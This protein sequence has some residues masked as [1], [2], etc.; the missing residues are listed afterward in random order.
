MRNIPILFIFLFLA[1]G[2]CGQ[3]TQAPG[4]TQ[5]LPP[6]TQS[7]KIGPQGGPSLLPTVLPV[8]KQDQS[9]PPYNPT[10]KPDP[11]QP[12]RVSLEAKTGA[13]T[14]V[15]PLEQFEINDF[16]L[17]GIVSGP[18][19]K[20][21]MVQDLTGKGFLVQVGSRIGKNGGKVIRIAD[22]EMVIEEPYR[23]FLGQKR[24]RKVDLKIHESK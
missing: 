18:G 21:A 14:R 4:S 3:Q 10:G 11:F 2:G 7:P 17:V 24:F 22:K 20:K 23:D 15:L 16:Q 12:P 13:K 5:K 19:V 8:E 1:G 9:A 6:I